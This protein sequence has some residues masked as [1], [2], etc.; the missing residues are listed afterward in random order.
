MVE[1]EHHKHEAFDGSST[2]TVHLLLWM[3]SSSTVA[4]EVETKDKLWHTHIFNHFILLFSLFV[5]IFMLICSFLTLICYFVTLPM[6][7]LFALDGNSL[8]YES[9]QIPFLYKLKDSFIVFQPKCCMPTFMPAHNTTS[10]KALVLR[11][12][13]VTAAFCWTLKDRFSSVC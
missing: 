13:A 1:P 4:V 12:S 2:E 7:C 10:P 3:F 9:F 11:N 6:C 5:F 8:F